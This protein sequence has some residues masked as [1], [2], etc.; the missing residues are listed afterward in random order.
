M[1]T[2]QLT[3]EIKT[4]A[5][6]ARL[7]DIYGNQSLNAQKK[8]YI[9]AIRQFEMLYGQRDVE[10]F[11]VSGRSEISG[12]HTDHENGCVLACSISL[13][14][15]AVAARSDGNT[16]RVKSEG[17]DEDICDIENLNA[18]KGGDA[19]YTSASIIA[20][21]CD[22]FLENGYSIGSF[23]AYTTSNV[24]KG[25]GLSSSAAFEDMIG[26][27]L[28]N[29]YNDGCVGETDIAM[30]SRHAENEFFGKPCGLMDQVAC[31][32]GGFVYIDFE[33]PRPIIEPVKFD[34]THHGYNL[35]IVNTGGNHAD[36]SPEYAA[37]TREMKDIASH[38][39]KTA[40]REVKEEEFFEN[41]PVLREKYGDRSVLRAY[42]FYTEQKRVAAQK[43]A[44]QAGD[45]EAF[46]SLTNESGNSSFKY[47]QNVYTCQ[48]TSEQGI[49]VALAVSEVLL[50]GKPHACR[51]HGGGFAGTVQCIL[52]QEDTE[53]YKQRIEKI[54]GEGSCYVLTV[55]KYG[56]VK[57]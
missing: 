11:S 26:C 33:T 8:R 17:F 12:N 9:E 38:F 6:D 52:R 51:V 48:N 14:I 47:L 44:L 3:E 43:E 24:L 20:G 54:F 4:G 37:V 30:I 42:H 49:S 40:L 57:L 35:C 36:L 22:G 23:C 28:S 34:L 10:L 50:A 46:L 32:F 21:V 1:I 19:K 29:F 56:A 39:G 27:I 25:S 16:I 13:D 53:E 41:I 45:I 55:R 2:T 5:L 31:A 15:I 7:C 18:Y